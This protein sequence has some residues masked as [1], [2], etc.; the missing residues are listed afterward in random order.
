MKAKLALLL[1]LTAA[2]STPLASAFTY[3]E[4]DLLL[5]FRKDGFNDVEFNLGT[6]SN[7]LGRPLG[8]PI[9]VTNWNWALVKSNFNNNLSGVKYV[10]GAA[11]ALNEAPARVW[12]SDSALL[13]TTP[14]TDLPGSRWRNLRAK[15]STVGTE[16]AALTVSNASLVWVVAASESSS[17]TSIASEASTL[18]VA[19]VCGFAPFSVE[20]DTP[21]TNL[22][23]E[24]KASSATPKPAAPLIGYFTLSAAGA[25]NF[26]P[27][28][29]QQRPTLIPPR[30]LAIS[31]AANVTTVT[32][33]TTNA[34][35][36]RL[37]FLNQLASPW[38]WASNAT[39]VAGDGTPKSLTDSTPG[40][41]R[42]YRVEVLP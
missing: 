10:V 4:A 37:H 17:Y 7:Y 34:L 18:D 9:A 40:S 25:L 23:Y 41:Q 14:P 2:G 1:A 31:R 38:A 36:Y 5:V 28:P 33:T 13:A 3:A 11:T 16:A 15:I 26:T 24:L 20:A 30:L 32:F 39:T 21:G 35:H 27:G 8:Q 29:L 22:F 42:F 12:C 6:V 19:T